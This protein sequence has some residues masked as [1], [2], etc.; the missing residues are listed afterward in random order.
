MKPGFFGPGSTRTKLNKSGIR[1][2]FLKPTYPRPVPVP[3]LDEPAYPESGPGYL[4]I[5]ILIF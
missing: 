1:M 5:L 3:D 4:L 2:P